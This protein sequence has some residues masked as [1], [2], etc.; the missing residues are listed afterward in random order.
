MCLYSE[1]IV[2]L[3]KK[4]KIILVVKLVRR[5]MVN[6]AN[7]FIVFLFRFT[8][9]ISIEGKTICFRFIVYRKISNFSDM[10]W[11]LSESKSLGCYNTLFNHE[12]SISF[13]QSH[14]SCNKVLS[15]CLANCF[16]KNQTY[17]VIKV[18]LKSEYC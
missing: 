11:L 17:A 8:C 16:K 9:C 13:H 10:P 3:S 1:T 5:R 12:F 2:R 18:N 14:Q 6:L 7:I 15:K 4:K